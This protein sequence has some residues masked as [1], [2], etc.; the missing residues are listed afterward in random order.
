MGFF[1]NARDIRQ[2][3]K[4]KTRNRIIPG[5]RKS[6]KGECSKMDKGNPPSNLPDGEMIKNEPPPNA[7]NPRNNNNE[8]RMFLAVVGFIII[9]IDLM[10]KGL[11]ERII[12]SIGPY[13]CLLPNISYNKDKQNLSNSLLI[14]VVF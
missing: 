10:K 3:K 5:I 7:P 1:I 12:S 4:P 11:H 6:A 9:K 14:M 8:I 2:G 13:I